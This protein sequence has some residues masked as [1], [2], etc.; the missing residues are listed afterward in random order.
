MAF[1]VGKNISD[2]ELLA[3]D[4]SNKQQSSHISKALEQVPDKF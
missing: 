4:I 1:G 2:V 3:T